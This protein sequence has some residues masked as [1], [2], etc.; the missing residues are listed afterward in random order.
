MG[1]PDEYTIRQLADIVLAATGSASK[2]EALPLPIDDP[3]VRKPDISLAASV[4]GW[5]PEVALEVG[6][7]HS[8]AYFQ[9][10]QDAGALN[11]VAGL[12]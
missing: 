11:S 4:L 10:L 5:K 2:L 1:N 3:M 7:G 9:G 8:I 6:L 12:D